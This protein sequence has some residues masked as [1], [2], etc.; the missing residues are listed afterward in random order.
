MAVLSVAEDGVGCVPMQILLNLAGLEGFGWV[1]ILQ[2][3]LP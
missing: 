2:N 3:P 1:V